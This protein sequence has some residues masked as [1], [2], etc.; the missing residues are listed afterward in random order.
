MLSVMLLHD[1]DH[2]FLT[3]D[4]ALLIVICLEFRL[5]SYPLLLSIGRITAFICIKMFMFHFEDAVYN[6][7]QEVSVVG[8][9]EDR[10]L[11]TGKILLKPP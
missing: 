9:D 11:I 6:F 1:T 2:I 10:S 5:S 4:L 7:I 8:D 3:P